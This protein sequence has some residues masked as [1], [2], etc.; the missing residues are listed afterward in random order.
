MHPRNKIRPLPTE[1]EYG[2]AH[3]MT[4]YYLGVTNKTAWDDVTER[5]MEIRKDPDTAVKFRGVMQYG[6]LLKEDILSES[7]YPVEVPKTLAG[8]AFALGFIHQLDITQLVYANEMTFVDALN[9]MNTQYSAQ[10]FERMYDPDESR[11]S[12]E[13]IKEFNSQYIYGM[14]EWGIA[15]VG[16]EAEA[17]ID[18]W[19]HEV[20]YHDARLARAFRLGHGALV[21]CAA[22]Y[23]RAINEDYINHEIIEGD[24]DKKAQSL[25][26]SNT[27]EEH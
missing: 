6:S 1:K 11:E 10:N 2:E 8:R 22:K 16:K 19:S 3:K 4:D 25:F 24:L 23:Q 18:G 17:I 12:A 14:G 9:A 20:Y 27:S 26:D 7:S 13:R 15:S 5:F 21:V